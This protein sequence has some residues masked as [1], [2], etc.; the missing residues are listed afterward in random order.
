MTLLRPSHQFFFMCSVHLPDE[1]CSKTFT[2]LRCVLRVIYLQWLVPAA[3]LLGGDD[4][5]AVGGQHADASD[6]DRG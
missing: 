3:L 4:Y 2:I 1:A 6:Q 5:P